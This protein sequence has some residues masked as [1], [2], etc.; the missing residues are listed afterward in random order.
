MSSIAIDELPS[1]ALVGNNDWNEDAY[2]GPCPPASGTNRRKHIYRFRLYAIDKKL[3]IGPRASR[4]D[5]V[6]AMEGH[7]VR[8][9]ALTGRYGE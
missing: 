5:I 9:F 8:G 6:S 7:I 1:G 3:G 4:S 2:G